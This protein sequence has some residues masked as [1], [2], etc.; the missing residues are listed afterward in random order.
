M[1]RDMKRTFWW[2]GMK[3]EVAEFVSR[4]VVCQMVK[5][6]RRKPPGLLQPLEIPV[7]KWE[8][9]S[10]DF[11]DGLPRSRKGNESIWV[12]VDRLTKLAHFIPLPST[13]NVRL[14]CDKYIKEVVRLHG[15]PL[16]IVSDRDALF[17]SNFWKG[18]QSAM[19][20]QLAMSTAYHP[21]TDGQTERVNQVLEDML[22]MCVLDS[23]K[24]WEDHLP[25]VEFSYNNSYQSI[26][27]MAPF[28]A[29]Y[30]RPC[31]SPMCWG[32]VGDSPMLGPEEVK[33]MAEKVH[34]IRDRMKAA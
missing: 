27:G 11:V 24:S 21:Q 34:L 26:I 16:T 8:D 20:T 25:Y 29:L 19:G 5:A 10:M 28:E 30:G 14:L 1:Y 32:E 18:L 22:R 3:R 2:E 15:V 23:G 33:E 31:R 7:W 17:V 6:E 13:R 4:C 12:I 9:I